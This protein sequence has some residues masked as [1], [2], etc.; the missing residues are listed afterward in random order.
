[1]SGERVERRRAAILA[2]DMRGSAFNAW[3]SPAGL[4]LGLTLLAAFT[5]LFIAAI[6][7]FA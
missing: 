7:A 6:I 1:M 3:A 2:A 5:A 4:T